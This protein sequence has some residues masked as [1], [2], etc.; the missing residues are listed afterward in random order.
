MLHWHHLPISSLC[1]IS[2]KF[3]YKQLPLRY[4]IMCDSNPEH[5]N[6]GVHATTIPPA[7]YLSGADVDDIRYL[8]KG[9]CFC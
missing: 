1:T 3:N 6:M 9:N 4:K 5:L 2:I 8:F 7:F